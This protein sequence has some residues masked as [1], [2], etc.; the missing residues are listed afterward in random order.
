MTQNNYAALGVSASKS[1]LHKA[2]DEAGIAPAAGLFAQVAEDLGGS[3]DY[4]SF[5]H[6]DGAGTKSI[7]PY[8]YFKDTGDRSLFAGL[9]QDALV[10][11]LD[12]IYCIGQPE[13][14]LLANAIARNSRLIDDQVLTLLFAAYKKLG[15]TLRACGIPLDIT[16]GETA[17]CPDVVRTLLVDAVLCGRIKKVN[18][19]NANNIVPGDLIL[20]FSSTGLASY[21][22][23][24]N[25][26]ISSNGLTLARHAM[27]CRK[28]AEDY[29]E[30]VDPA[31]DPALAY[32][33]PFRTTDEAPGLGMSVGQALSSP[34][35]TYAPLLVKIFAALGNKIHGIVHLTGGGQSKVLRFG[36][37]NLYIKDNLFDTPPLFSLIAEHG[38]VPW[39]EMYQVFNMGHRLELYLE[40]K[41]ADEVLKIAASCGI[42]AKQVGRVEK[43]PG[44]SSGANKVLLK[45]QHGVFE[46][47]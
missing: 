39:K 24:P 34:T 33:G 20:G 13:K 29:P 3:E 16:G 18:L 31:T 11:N 35:R 19:I 32:R 41:Y 6:C 28:Y 21:E 45:T 30:V 22:E 25:S 1:G 15:S 43:L 2:L 7:I 14:L 23:A 36:S 46:Y 17:D 47:C 27:L 42:A 8:L 26:G 4:Y 38:K 9:A 37:N 5:A 40:E 10:M 44:S 12:D